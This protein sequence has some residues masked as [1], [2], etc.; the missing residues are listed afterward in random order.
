MLAYKNRTPDM[1]LAKFKNL[2]RQTYPNRQLKCSRTLSILQYVRFDL[3]WFQRCIIIIIMKSSLC[4]A[5]QLGLA[6]GVQLGV[7]VSG[8]ES[9]SAERYVRQGNVLPMATR[10]KISEMVFNE[11]PA[12]IFWNNMHPK[13]IPFF[14]D[15]LIKFI[16]M[17]Q[18]FQ[19][20]LPFCWFNLCS[21]RIFRS[22][23]HL[24]IVQ[25]HLLVVTVT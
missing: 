20:F 5:R 21:C 10:I 16:K 1:T 13:G 11:R 7:L 2:E 23:S 6:C 15:I 17:M 18:W 24:L 8:Q 4:L 12:S 9:K 25:I 19:W 14:E 22:C 3:I